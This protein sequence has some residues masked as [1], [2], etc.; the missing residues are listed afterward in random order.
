MRILKV[1]LIIFLCMSLISCAING[2]V[3][4]NKVFTQAQ[5]Q[6][7]SKRDGQ[8]IVNVAGLMPSYFSDIKYEP[9]Q[10]GLTE[11]QVNTIGLL[12][13][14]VDYPDE[15]VLYIS[16]GTK[17]T[18]DYKRIDIVTQRAKNLKKM[19][20]KKVKEIHVA[21]LPNQEEDSAYLRLLG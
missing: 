16:L 5:I 14:K 4:S 17:N 7:E 20:S 8:K 11:E 13:S 2:G 19:L 1:P 12:F 9:S 21:I 18:K 10:T 15:Y 6:F 3:P